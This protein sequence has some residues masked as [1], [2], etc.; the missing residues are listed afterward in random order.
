MNPKTVVD[1]SVA[2]KWFTKE[3]G[4]MQASD[5]RRAHLEE[6]T[7]LVAPDLLVYEVANALRYNKNLVK[8][9]IKEAVRALK[10]LGVRLYPPSEELLGRAIDLAADYSIT[11]YDASYLALAHELDAQLVTADKS[12]AEKNPD[13]GIPL[14]KYQPRR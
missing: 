8:S 12:L 13:R 4:H 6:K 14:E 3:R 10:L 9:D 5:L 2:V 7:L 1:A 11:I